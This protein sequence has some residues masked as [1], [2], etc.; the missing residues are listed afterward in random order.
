MRHL[1]TGQVLKRL[2]DLTMIDVRSA[3]AYNGWR[4]NEEA[5]GGHIRGAKHLPDPWLEVLT[6]EELTRILDGKGIKP[7]RSIVVYG[8]HAGHG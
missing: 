5:R 1:T 4:L 6:D 7:G 3:A 2:D 8:D